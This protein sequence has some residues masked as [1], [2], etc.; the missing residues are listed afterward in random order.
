MVLRGKMKKELAARIIKEIL[1]TDKNFIEVSRQ[2]NLIE[3]QDEYEKLA[4][5]VGNIIGLI[6]TDVVIPIIKEYPDLDPDKKS[7]G[8]SE[9]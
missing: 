6:Y 1:E 7:E 2:L 5:S 9:G 3:N 8:S 4:R